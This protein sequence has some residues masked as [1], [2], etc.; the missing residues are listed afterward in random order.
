V[1]AGVEDVDV[2]AL[3]AFVVASQGIDI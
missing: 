3:V 2:D 1:G